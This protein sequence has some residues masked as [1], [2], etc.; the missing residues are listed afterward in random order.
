MAK[1]AIANQVAIA[2]DAPEILNALDDPNISYGTYTLT[3]LPYR[4]TLSVKLYTLLG[5]NGAA[6]SWN[7]VSCVDVSLP[8]SGP[9]KI[10]TL[11]APVAG[12]S[13]E[14]SIIGGSKLIEPGADASATVTTDANGVAKVLVVAGTHPGKLRVRVKVV[15]NPANAFFVPSRSM[16]VVIHPDA[17]HDDGNPYHFKAPSLIPTQIVGRSN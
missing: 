6:T 16:D 7:D 2:V 5:Q 1:S 17:T 14:V 11:G 9:H 4:R 10:C 13:I 8:Y 3:G 15:S 12:A